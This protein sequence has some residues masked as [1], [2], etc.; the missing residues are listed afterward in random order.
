MQSP[1]DWVELQSAAR[2]ASTLLIGPGEAEAIALAKMLGATLLADDAEARM[3]ATGLGVAVTGTVGVLER[4]A[5]AGLLQLPDALDRLRSTSFRL[6]AKLAQEALDR[7]RLRK[8]VSGAPAEQHN[9]E[10]SGGG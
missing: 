3:V 10:G 4:G 7:D 1:P 6:S 5:A 9:V 8:A 2:I